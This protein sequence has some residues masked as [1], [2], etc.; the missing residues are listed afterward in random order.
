MDSLTQIAIALDPALMMRACGIVAD[1]WQSSVLRSTHPRHLLCCTRQGGKSTVTAAKAL[2]TV[3]Y[4]SPALVLLLSPSQRQSGELFRSVMEMYDKLGRPVKQTNETALGIEFEN[5]SRIVALPG[6]EETIRGYAKV[7][8]LI[9][10]EAS[11]ISDDLYRSVRPML[12]V[13]GGKMICL[14]TPW[15]QRGFFY[16]E[17]IKGEEWQRT[18]ITAIDCPRI[19]EAFLIQ[20][21]KSMPQAF[22]AQEYMCEFT[23]V[24]GSAFSHADIMAAMDDKLEPLFPTRDDILDVSLRPLV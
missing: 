7:S 6:K 18:K 24:E 20:E 19:S 16:D 5:G 13:S 2:H 11:R 10:D 15:G 23:E 21:R 12:A 9:L 8:L 3:M 22:F 17:W 1:P 4:Q 14:S